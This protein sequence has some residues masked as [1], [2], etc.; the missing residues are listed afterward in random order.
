MK[1]EIDE[2]TKAGLKVD[3]EEKLNAEKN[4]LQT[5]EKR[6]SLANDIVTL[7][8]D[9]ENSVYNNLSKTSRLIDELLRLDPSLANLKSNI[10]STLT[11]LSEVYR[12]LVEYRE[13]INFN[14]ERLD[15]VLAR[16][17]L[18]NRLKKKHRKDVK[19]ILLYLEQIK[20]ELVQIEV[21][22]EEIKKIEAEIIQAEKKIYK[23]SEELSKKRRNAARMMEKRV[24]EV[25][26]NLGMEKAQFEIRFDEKEI[27]ETGKDNVE[28]YI[29]TNPGEELKPLRKV[30]SGGEI[31]RITLAL[32]TILS[33]ADRIPILIFDEVDTGIG[34]RVAE[35]VGELLLSASKNRQILCITHLPQISV[36]GQNHILVKKEIKER[37][38]ITRILK[39]D[40]EA[41]KMEIARMLGGKEITKKVVEHAEE[42]L[43]KI[44]Q[45]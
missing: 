28:F 13:G 12:Q 2:I 30:G 23:Q 11:T 7:L 6:A 27:S 40:E 31:S 14:E 9:A 5:C 16:L 3:E 18:I 26:K 22:E 20:K 15:E 38:T 45:R 44:K 10:E 29:S 25:L 21:S 37:T 39:L 32:K 35:A 17:E 36:Y 24:L 1:Y 42:I 19:E 43:Q 8:Y 41:R 34:G 4:L 33:D